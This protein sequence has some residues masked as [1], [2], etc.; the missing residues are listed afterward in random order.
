MSDDFDYIE[1]TEAVREIVTK[2]E[3]CNAPEAD[4]PC[5]EHE[6][7]L[8]YWQRRNLEYIECRFC[9]ALRYQVYRKYDED[10]L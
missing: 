4:Q 6:S 1:A 9:G 5:D 10:G 8:H 3:L 2:D 7:G